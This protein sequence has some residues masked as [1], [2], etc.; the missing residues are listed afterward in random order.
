MNEFKNY[1]L[2]RKKALQPLRPYLPGED[3]SGVSVAATDT[4]EIGGMIAKNPKNPDDM[5]YVSKQAFRDT[6]EGPIE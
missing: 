6:Y 4:P 5:W 2:Y 1:K 3:L